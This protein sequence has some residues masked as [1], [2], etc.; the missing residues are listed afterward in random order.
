M[1]QYYRTEEKLTARDESCK[2]VFA[3]RKLERNLIIWE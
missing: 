2:I 3:Y 1:Q